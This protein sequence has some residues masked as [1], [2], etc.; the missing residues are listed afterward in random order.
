M[1]D[2]QALKQGNTGGKDA[3]LGGQ[4]AMDR[5]AADCSVAKFHLLGS[6]YQR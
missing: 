6:K 5:L 1:P 3:G 4:V 2:F